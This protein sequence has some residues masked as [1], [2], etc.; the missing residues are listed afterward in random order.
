MLS[1]EMNPARR[2][3]TSTNRSDTPRL[4]PTFLRLSLDAAWNGSG[5]VPSGVADSFLHT[6]VRRDH[7]LFT[8]PLL[9]PPSNNSSLRPAAQ[10]GP[11]NHI[12]V[13]MPTFQSEL[14]GTSSIDPPFITF[15]KRGTNELGVT[16][17][18]LD[19]VEAGN[20]QLFTRESGY[21]YPNVVMFMQVRNGLSARW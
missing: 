2:S 6:V 18:G 21:R 10:A 3:I 5:P 14:H 1:K 9:S 20:A 19:N 13:P 11:P 7:I 16:L 17:G 12:L 8:K 4:G 15:K